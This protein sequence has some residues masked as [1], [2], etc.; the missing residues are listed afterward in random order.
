MQQA[1]NSDRSIAIIGAGVMGTAIATLNAAHG[2]KVNLYDSDAGALRRLPERAATIARSLAGSTRGTEEILAMIETHQCL[3][4]SVQGVFLAHEVIHEDLEAK[5]TLLGQLDALCGRDVM[6]ATN[7][8]SFLL[9]DLCG[10]IRDRHRFLGIHYVS[11]AYVIRAVEII[12]ARFTDPAL[13]ERARQYLQS[14]H[15]VGVVVQERPGFLINRIQY[16][17]KAEICRIIDEGTASVE[18]IDTAVRLAIGPRLALWGP[19][20]QEDLTTSKQTVLAVTQYICQALGAAHFAPTRTLQRLAD[21]GQQGAASGAG[22]YRWNSE[23]QERIAERDRQLSVLLEW[24]TDH[25]GLQALG[26]MGENRAFIENA[27][28]QAE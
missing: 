9:S 1:V 6:L 23:Y 12:V 25:D 10:A 20:M 26:A 14:I 18:D 3:E 8:S 17:L 7:T 24:L 11:P 5:R 27:S 2:Y 15:Q 4:S 13:I 22:W 19:L 28:R 21:S 16:A